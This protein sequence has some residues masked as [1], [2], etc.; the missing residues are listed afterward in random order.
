MHDYYMRFGLESNPFPKNARQI[1]LDTLQFREVQTRLDRLL[2][3]GG[4]GILTGDPGKGKTTSVRIWTSALNPSLYKVVYN[5]LS[6]V[7]VNDFYR[8]LVFNFGLEPCYRKPDNFRLIQE[9][10]IRYAEKRITPI[11]VIDEAMHVCKGILHDLKSLFNFEMD[12][13]DLAIVIMTGLP[14]LNRTLNLKVHESLR[15]RITM[16]YNMEGITRE[17]SRQYIQ[18]K[19]EGVGCIREVFTANAVEALANAAN[20][21]PR[22]LNKLADRAMQIADSKNLNQIDADIVG[23]AVSAIE[24]K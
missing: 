5:K 20:G 18:K 22:M 2:S 9:E 7:S 8:N 4:I 21:V 19:L 17:E 3:T 24:L 12:S 15:Q 6:T 10:I 11:I 14:E 16:N 1:I 13:R 23:E